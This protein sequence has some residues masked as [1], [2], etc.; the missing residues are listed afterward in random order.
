MKIGELEN[1]L[2]LDATVSSILTM[3]GPRLDVE[4]TF[5]EP[6]LNAKLMKLLTSRAETGCSVVHREG[7]GP[8]ALVAELCNVRDVRA[9]FDRPQRTARLQAT[10]RIRLGIEGAGGETSTHDLT[11]D[12]TPKVRDG[13]LILVPKALQISSAPDGL[14]QGLLGLLEPASIPLHHCLAGLDL[15][16]EDLVLETGANQI[17][18]AV[19][20]E[21]ANALSVVPCFTKG[22]LILHI[23]DAVDAQTPKR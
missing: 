22:K 1:P 19:S 7:N 16:V 11:L 17:D 21:T 23:R 12:A 20:T 15:D 13:V 9:T 3:N 8:G 4:A 2:T 5:S 10:A 6:A 14:G 18:I